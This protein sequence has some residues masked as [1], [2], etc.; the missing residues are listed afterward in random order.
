MTAQQWNAA[1]Y[2]TE[3]RFV[4]DLAAPLVDLLAPRPGEEILDL[5]CGD[6]ALSAA[7]QERGAKVI[8]IDAS[9]E[10]VAAARAPRHRRPGDA[11]RGH[12]LRAHLRRGLQQRGAALDAD[13]R[14]C[15]RASPGR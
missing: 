1:R 11:G 13:S 14:P 12:R 5:G 7:I 4:A 3:A 2:G 6:G 8:G 10:M 15:S 9:G